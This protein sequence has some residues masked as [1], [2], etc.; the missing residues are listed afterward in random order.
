MNPRRRAQSPTKWIVATVIV[1]GILAG[2]TWIA[3][4]LAS[5]QVVVTDAT[6]GPVVQ[7]FYSTGTVQPEREF[8][9]RANVAGTIKSVHVDK[10]DTVKAQQPLAVIDDPELSFNVHKAQAEVQE[11]EKRA[12]GATS[13][14]LKE[15]D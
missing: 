14:V 7:A 13:P 1:V 2:G 4:R 6:S 8:P 5:P 9:I 12:D 10:G 3:L 11:K 15:F